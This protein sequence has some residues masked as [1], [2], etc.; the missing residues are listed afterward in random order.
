[1]FENLWEPC[2]WYVRILIY[3]KRDYR[4]RCFKW[5]NF[6]ALIMSYDKNILYH[7]TVYIT[8]IWFSVIHFIPGVLGKYP[9]NVFIL[10]IFSRAYLLNKLLNWS[11]TTLIK[12]T[13]I[14]VIIL[15]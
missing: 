15:P 10:A 6:L 12:F 7:K 13:N 9:S 11:I 2:L 14:L 1:M 8:G 5:G 4:R 3:S